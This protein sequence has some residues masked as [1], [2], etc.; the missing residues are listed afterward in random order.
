M[1]TFHSEQ[2]LINLLKAE[3]QSSSQLGNGFKV[4]MSTQYMPITSS[5]RPLERSSKSAMRA[6]PLD[7]AVLVQALLITV[8]VSASALGGGT[9]E[10]QGKSALNQKAV[11]H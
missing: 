4:L 9:F 8:M 11:G 1:L 2:A 7:P 5:R 10:C 6:L 3:S